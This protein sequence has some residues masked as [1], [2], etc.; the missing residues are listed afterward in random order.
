MSRQRYGA[1][2]LFWRL[3]GFENPDYDFKSIARLNVWR[4]NSIILKGVSL[5]KGCIVGAGSV[6]TKSVAQERCIIAGNPA[7]VVK[8]DIDW[9]VLYPDLYTKA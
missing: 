9:D 5:A 7:K 4:V 2:K 6:V 8:S 3:Q 1:N